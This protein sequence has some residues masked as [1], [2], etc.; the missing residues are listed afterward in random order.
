[1][2]RNIDPCSHIIVVTY[3][4]QGVY[5]NDTKQMLQSRRKDHFDL[6]MCLLFLLF[7]LIFI[8]NFLPIILA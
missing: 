7:L 6:N 8:P 5:Y 4:L 1:M 2:I 3:F